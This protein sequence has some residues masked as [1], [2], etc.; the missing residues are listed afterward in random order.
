[1]FGN[2]ELPVFAHMATVFVAPT[3]L[4]QWWNDTRQTY[5]C[6]VSNIETNKTD[7]K[8]E[9]SS[10]FNLMINYHDRWLRNKFK[11]GMKPMQKLLEKVYPGGILTVIEISGF[12]I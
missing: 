7:I 5:D 2:Q 3:V 8:K 12:I 11:H 1:M 4:G 10:V 6:V 9:F